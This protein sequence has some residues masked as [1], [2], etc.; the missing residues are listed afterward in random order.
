MRGAAEA[1]ELEAEVDKRDLGWLHNAQHLPRD[2]AR[3]RR[4]PGER[5]AL[6]V[7]ARD[8]MD[9]QRLGEGSSCPRGRLAGGAPEGYLRWLRTRGAARGGRR[10]EAHRGARAAPLT[11]ASTARPA[12]RGR[13]VM[14]YKTEGLQVTG[15]KKTPLRTHP[16]AFYALLLPG[17]EVEAAHLNVGERGGPR[18]AARDPVRVSHRSGRPSPRRCVASARERRCR[19]WAREPGLRDSAA[20]A[21]LPEGTLGE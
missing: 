10:R 21:A 12:E 1:D 17:Q 14:D 11:A 8:A 6:L 18:G 16:L 19:R 13:P 5:A 3:T 4:L 15:L 9:S 20:P 2:P 7:T